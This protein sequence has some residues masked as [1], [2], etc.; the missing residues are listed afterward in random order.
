VS[1]SRTLLPWIVPASLALAGC[2]IPGPRASDA[3]IAGIPRDEVQVH[4]D[5]F[6]GHVSYLHA[7]T[8]DT[9]RVV[10]V[11]G[12]PGAATAWSDFLLHVPAGEEYIALDRPG[13][14]HSEPAGAV[15]SLKSQA[16]ALRPFLDPPG[17]A[18]VILVGH[19]LGAGVIAEAAELYPDR[20][21]G[22]VFVAGALDP[23]LEDPDWVHWLQSLGTVPPISWV[24]SREWDNA[25]R[26]LIAYESQ[27][28]AL[29]PR[30]RQ[31]TQPIRIIHGTADD[32]VPF[33]NVAYMHHMLSHAPVSITRIPDGT[34]FLPWT[35][36]ALVQS[37][38]QRIVADVCG[39]SRPCGTK[40]LASAPGDSGNRTGTGRSPATAGVSTC[41][42][43]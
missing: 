20:V 28:R 5:T 22:L 24:L 6:D 8:P 9:A 7:G 42:R 33:A 3:A 29:A 41:P 10:L 19:S 16:Q 36:F 35:H 2:A 1:L 21:A 14:G 37:R 30:L 38:I 18:P 12:T 43:C 32:L 26:E 23:D 13:F 39:G 25:N 34:H 40:Q 17:G 4:T 15:V 27:L 11:H 31:I